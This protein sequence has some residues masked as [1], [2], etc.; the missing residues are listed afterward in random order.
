MAFKKNRRF[1]NAFFAF[2]FYRELAK[3]LINRITLTHV[4]TKCHIFKTYHSFSN[5]SAIYCK[6]K[7]HTDEG[8]ESQIK[9]LYTGY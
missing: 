4:I 6:A 5:R 2:R 9:L 3:I 8:K 1:K 7:I